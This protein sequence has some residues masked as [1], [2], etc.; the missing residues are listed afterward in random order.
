MAMQMERHERLVVAVHS[1]TGP[2]DDEW[3]RWMDLATPRLGRDLR[4]MVEVYGAVGPSARQRQ[5]GAALLG[6]VDA[7][8][9]VLSN[10]LIVR[11]LVTAMNW[12]GFPNEAF[13]PGHFQEAGSYLALT[14]AELQL[15][16]DRLGALR[17]AAGITQ[18][19]P[20][21]H[22]PASRPGRA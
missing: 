16:M 6:K 5:A 9:A 21:S 12:I 15:A 4:A 14:P 11:G 10:S 18:A 13:A 8:F 22:A 1:E 3:A 19:P 2:T 7:R 17:R 20:A